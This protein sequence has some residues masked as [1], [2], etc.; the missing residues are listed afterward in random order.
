M[1]PPFAFTGAPR[2][3]KPSIAPRTLGSSNRDSIA[4][5][6]VPRAIGPSDAIWRGWRITEFATVRSNLALGR[7]GS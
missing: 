1:P 6:A 2:A 5:T 3:A 4:S 7:K